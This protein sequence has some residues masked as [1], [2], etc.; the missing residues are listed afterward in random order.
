[1]AEFYKDD[2]NMTNSYVA[3]FPKK[4]E[5]RYTALGKRQ[6]LPDHQF[7]VGSNTRRELADDG[8][9]ASKRA[10]ASVTVTETH[11]WELVFDSGYYPEDEKTGQLSMMSHRPGETRVGA[12]VS[13]PSMRSSVPTLLAMATQGKQNITHDV[14]LSQHSSRLINKVRDKV[15]IQ[16]PEK[17]PNAAPTT[18]MDKSRPW[19]GTFVE[20][21]G[22]VYGTDLFHADA[23]LEKVP[24]FEVRMAK[25]TVR[26]TLRGRKLSPQFDAHVGEQLK[27]EGM[28]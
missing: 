10:V 19:V 22:E 14:N 4:T 11:P 12:L 16:R 9:D 2:D 20:R 13:D 5:T 24:D 1:M 26:R 25:D 7:Y 23:K 28:D 18:S 15:D 3:S 17:N 8:Y 6:E 21:D 27:F